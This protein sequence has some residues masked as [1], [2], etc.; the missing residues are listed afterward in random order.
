MSLRRADIGKVT[1]FAQAGIC[2]G[3]LKKQYNAFA[4]IVRD[5]YMS[6]YLQHL[7][8]LLARFLELKSVYVVHAVDERSVLMVEGLN[9]I[10]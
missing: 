7:H 9:Q 4:R 1:N 6:E 5:E 10:K 3:R 2:K 8:P